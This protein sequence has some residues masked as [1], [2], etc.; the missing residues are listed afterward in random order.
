VAV[1]AKPLTMSA[2]APYGDVL[3]VPA[4]AGRDYF[5]RSLANLRPGARPS[6]S[7]A[8]RTEIASLPYVATLMERHEFSSQ[9]FVPIDVG[10][11]L[12]MVAPHA[13][14]GGP[15]M[16]RAEAFLPQPGQGVTFAANVW[17]HPLTVF[18]RQGAFVI[19]MWLAGGV[20]DEEF[21]TLR[22]PITVVEA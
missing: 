12:V 22:T 9:S 7:L 2:F 16:T 1:I 14:G 5:D 13:A 19:S 21:F 17:H 4:D 11:W 18:D 8:R 15:D 6:L 20:G 10:R 3:Q